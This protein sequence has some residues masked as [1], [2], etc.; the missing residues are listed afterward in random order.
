LNSGILLLDC[1]DRRGIVAAIADF[2]Y[3]HGANILHADQHQ[4][5]EAGMFFMRIEW[6]L[7]GFDLNQ[8]AVGLA[9]RTP[10]RGRFR[11]PLSTLPA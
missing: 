2:L 9:G 8:L 5:N 3:A 7:D 6:S 1:P 4:D 10:T 11:F